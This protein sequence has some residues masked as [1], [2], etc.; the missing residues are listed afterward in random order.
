MPAPFD[1]SG[2]SPG[3]KPRRRIRQ[4]SRGRLLRGLALVVVGVPLGAGLASV[5]DRRGTRPTPPPTAVDAE[6]VNEAA[7][8]WCAP[9]FEPIAG[10]GCLAAAETPRAGQP[11]IVYLH[12]RYARDAATEEVERQRRLALRATTRGF[13]VLALRGGVGVC[14]APE[15]ANWVC[16]PSN[17]HNADR[18]PTFV[19]AWAQALATAHE[20]TG[21][22]ARF[23]LGFSSGGYFAG[24]IV[25]RG[26]FEVDALVVAHGGPV[27]PVHALRG[28]PPLL[29]LSADDDVAQDD[30]IR[31]DEDLAREQWAHD[32]YARSGVHDLTDED[33][34]AALAFFSR[35]KERLPLDPPLPLH[36]PV[37]HERD[38]G[39]G[40]ES[41][42]PSTEVIAPS[43]P[44]DEPPGGQVDDGDNM[45]DASSPW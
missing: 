29:L 40:A 30:M 32:S 10:D 45:E 35:A 41:S 42:E 37:R 17:E 43:H 1:F 27:E 11:L 3:S 5:L 38:A 6:R 22:R 13:A 33:I 14:T 26:L 19:T 15:L 39:V 34:G 18:A 8:D 7:A 28:K 20:R 21:S 23:L 16:W 24:L 12:G 9:G 25:A 36:R 44:S 4:D 2:N 31:F